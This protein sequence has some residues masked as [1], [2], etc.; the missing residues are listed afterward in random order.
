MS[1]LVESSRY[2]DTVWYLCNSFLD[3]K[4]FAKD[5]YVY[6]K[7]E[8]FFGGEQFEY[9]EKWFGENKKSSWMDL[10]GVDYVKD[11]PCDPYSDEFEIN[12]PLIDDYVITKKPKEKEYPVIVRYSLTD[13]C[14]DWC[15]IDTYFNIYNVLNQLE[16]YGKYKGILK[17]DDEK[18][19]NY[20]PVSMAKQIVRGRGL[21]G[22]LGYLEMEE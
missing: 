5:V 2:L 16:D 15:S 13:N 20:I 1:K 6:K 21:G 11:D 9:E 19:E 8:G 18:C 10:F 14:L 17:C 4:Q 7:R 12:N 3:Y 22:V